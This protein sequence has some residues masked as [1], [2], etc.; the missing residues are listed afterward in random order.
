MVEERELQETVPKLEA[1][2]QECASLKYL[3][4]ELY[5]KRKKKEKK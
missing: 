4:E 1:V 2:I 5:K 3:L